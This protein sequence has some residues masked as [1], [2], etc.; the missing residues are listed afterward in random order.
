MVRDKVLEG[1]FVC[2]AEMY[3]RGVDIG[4]FGG[5]GRCEELLDCVD[6]WLPE[7]FCDCVPEDIWDIVVLP[8]FV[9]RCINDVLLV[10]V[11]EA[12]PPMEFVRVGTW[13][14]G[15]DSAGNAPETPGGELS[16]SNTL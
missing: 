1:V 16:I 15:V 3:T 11:R 8:L 12:A 5:E 9:V 14:A 13:L 4:L 2:D 7:S 6:V 10:G